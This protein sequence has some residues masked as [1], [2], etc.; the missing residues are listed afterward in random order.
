M[1][2]H[3]VYKKQ[4]EQLEEDEANGYMRLVPLERKASFLATSIKDIDEY[5]LEARNVKT[6]QIDK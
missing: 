2:L 6:T 3:S 4:I 5:L 1:L